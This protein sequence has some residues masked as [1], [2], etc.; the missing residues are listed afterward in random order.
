MAQ[1]IQRPSYFEG[2][3]LA[4]RDLS[5]AVDYA[6]GRADRHDQ[7]LHRWGVAAG[8]ALVEQAARTPSGV[9]YV[10]VTVGAGVAI[11]GAGRELVLS[12]P[13]A[14]RAIDFERSNVQVEDPGAW[15]PVLIR[16]R[17]EPVPASGTLGACGAGVQQPT[18][19]NEQAEIVFGRPGTAADLA[20]QTPPAPGE[21]TTDAAPWSVLIGY[22]Q[23]SKDATNFS[24]TSISGDGTEVRYAG[25]SA[26][27]VASPGSSVTLLT[28]PETEPGA[29]LARIDQQELSF[30]LQDGSGGMT[31]LFTVNRKGDVTAGGKPL[32]GGV[33][34]ESGLVSHGMRV[35][36]PANVTEQAVSDGKV[37][38]HVQVT[39]LIA[40]TPPQGKNSGGTFVDATLWAPERCFVDADRRVS[41]KL[42]VLY[43][44]QTS[45]L[46][47]VCNYT[48]IAFAMG[49]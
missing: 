11:D 5:S 32:G 2:Q 45:T 22:V 21:D 36:L 43:T 37:A 15:Y 48:I 29:T 4:A 47:A 27:V 3:I 44:D 16:R 14:L 17:D 39:P 41:C 33:R 26:A 49:N 12:D 25:V 18:R 46:P 19:V 24:A 8:L 20:A 23:W 35:P 7:L 42:R 34:V 28:R 13:Y 38:L 6:R 1:P 10:D 30:G 40:D 9:A 31:K